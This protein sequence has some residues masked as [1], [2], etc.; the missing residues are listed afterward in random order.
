[1]P[2]SQSQL[3]RCAM[4]CASERLVLILSSVSSASLRSVMSSAT[5]MPPM[6]FPCSSQSGEKCWD[7]HTLALLV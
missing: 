3:P 5:A 7:S 2:T 1:M 6:T 4:R